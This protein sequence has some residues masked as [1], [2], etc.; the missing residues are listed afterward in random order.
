MIKLS[1]VLTYVVAVSICLLIVHILTL[2]ERLEV[3]ERRVMALKEI[4]TVLNNDHV[5]L[6]KT[7]VRQ[8]QDLREAAPDFIDCDAGEF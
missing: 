6:L 2:H 1:T 4:Q 3:L 7:Y 5:F 8:R